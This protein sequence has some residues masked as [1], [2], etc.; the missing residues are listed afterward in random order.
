MSGEEALGKLGKSGAGVSPPRSLL[1]VRSAYAPE[2]E[3]AT[4]EPSSAKVRGPVWFVCNRGGRLEAGGSESARRY[5]GES[6]RTSKDDEV[7]EKLRSVSCSQE[8]TG[9]SDELLK[10]SNSSFPAA[11]CRGVIFLFFEEDVLAAS[12]PGSSGNGIRLPRSPR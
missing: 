6:G 5:A 3:L 8:G 2:G 1:I 10:D 12:C 11:D 9:I 7:K 4:D